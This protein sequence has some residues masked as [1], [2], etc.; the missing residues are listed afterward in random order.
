[1]HFFRPCGTK[2]KVY[3]LTAVLV[4]EMKVMEV[5]PPSNP[6]TAVAAGVM[7]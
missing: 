3:E 6:L 2:K 7:V 1:M 4:T 5:I